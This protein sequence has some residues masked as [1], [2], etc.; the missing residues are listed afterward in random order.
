MNDSGVVCGI[1]YDYPYLN[2][3]KVDSYNYQ[4]NTDGFENKIRTAIRYY[5]G[6]TSNGNIFFT[7]YDENGLEYCI[8]KITPVLKP[9]FMSG[10][11]LY[12]RTGNM[13]QVLKSDEITWFV[14]ERYLKRNQSVLQPKTLSETEN[15]EEVIEDDTTAIESNEVTKEVV[16]VIAETPIISIKNTDT[17]IW[18]YLTFYIN[19]DWTFQNKEITSDD[20]EYQLPILD[21]LK[22]ERM[23]M[24]YKN[25]CV[26]VVIPYDII[27][28]KGING[29]KLKMKG[30]IYKNGWNINSKIVTMFCI[31]HTD[32]VV[33]NSDKSD[34]TSWIKIH[35][36]TAISVHSSL[37]LE[38]N[39]LIN[40]KLDATLTSTYPLSRDNC[41]LI[42]GL[43]LKDSQTSGYLG[44]KT[45]E[46]NYQKSIKLL[47]QLKE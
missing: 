41:H 7:F 10:S 16:P 39:V 11:K 40:P 31:N 1:H 28:P 6:S 22:K 47:E 2:S 3:S 33:F 38:G 45:T 30:K 26:N 18:Y 27:N 24:V 23:L 19:G 32:M 17:K 5:L 36:V 9:V 29:R 46:R 35:T 12:Q 20:V 4:E 21:S 44:F 13:T 42:S 37:G 25:G 34:D 15:I 8:I 14:E 43:L